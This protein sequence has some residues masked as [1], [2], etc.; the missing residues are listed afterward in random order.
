MLAT[1]RSAG[2]TLELNLGNLLH[3]GNEACK[4]G[5]SNLALNPREDV[6]RSPKQ[7]YQSVSGPK[8]KRT[9]VPQKF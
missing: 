8:K 5:G 1:K 4:R 6:T 9:D 2:V 7:G 3:A